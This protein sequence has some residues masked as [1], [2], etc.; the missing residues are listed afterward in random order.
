[1]EDSKRRRSSLHSLFGSMDDPIENPMPANNEGFDEFDAKPKKPSVDHHIKHV[2]IDIPEPLPTHQSS[3][4]SPRDFKQKKSFVGNVNES[5]EEDNLP[6][7]FVKKGLLSIKELNKQF[8]EANLYFAII[9]VLLYFGL[10]V[11][12]YE[13]M[14]DT[15]TRLDSF[16]FVIC[17]IF[18]IGK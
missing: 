8:M 14:C 15:W 3:R 1:M 2:S 7:A 16:Y 13:Y 5:A 9:I 17:T 11:L 10:G 18:T 4:Q 6:R 12:V